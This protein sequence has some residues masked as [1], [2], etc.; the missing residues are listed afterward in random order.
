L[1]LYKETGRLKIRHELRK[2]AIPGPY[3][4]LEVLATLYC[5]ILKEIRHT[6]GDGVRE[7]CQ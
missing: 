4:L 5:D 3:S 7:F 6:P 2:N 1:R